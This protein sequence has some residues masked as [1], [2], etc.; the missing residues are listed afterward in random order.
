MALDQDRSIVLVGF[1]AKAAFSKDN[2]SRLSRAP[3]LS[4]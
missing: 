1:A 4:E 2:A 3:L